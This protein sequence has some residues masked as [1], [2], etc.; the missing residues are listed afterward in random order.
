MHFMALRTSATMNYVSAISSCFSLAH[1][2]TRFIDEPSIFAN[3]PI[4]L[5]VV[6]RTLEDEALIAMSEIVDDAIQVFLEEVVSG[7]NKCNAKDADVN[8]T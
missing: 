8:S 3:A 7:E 6:A 1:I 5:Q 2:S 4:S